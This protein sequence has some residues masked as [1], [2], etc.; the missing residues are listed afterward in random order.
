[1]VASALAPNK[2]YNQ[3]VF[4]RG[5]TRIYFG[6]FPYTPL[7]DFG[8]GVQVV[9]RKGYKG[10]YFHSLLLYCIRQDMTKQFIDTI[11]LEIHLSFGMIVLPHSN[12]LF[13]LLEIFFFK[14]LIIFF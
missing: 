11:F 4:C 10:Y 5:I 1:M 2:K 6:G 8:I 13:C 12:L 7:F 9:F 3:G 14:H